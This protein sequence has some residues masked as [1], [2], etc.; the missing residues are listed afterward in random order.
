MTL[1]DFVVEF[2]PGAGPFYDDTDPG[3]L[4]L[5][6][7]P[8][9]W[10][11]T[12]DHSS[13]DITGDIDLRIDLTLEDWHQGDVALLAKYDTATANRSFIFWIQGS[14]GGGK[15]SL[16]WTTDGTTATGHTLTSTVVPSPVDGRLAVRVTLDV[17]N[18]ASGHTATFYTAPTIAGS[19]TTLGTAV[20]DTGTTSFF[21]SAAA[22]SIGAFNNGTPSGAFRPLRGTV[23]AAEVRN[24][25]GGTAVAD[26]DFAGHAAAS[27]SIVD[28]AGRT[29]SIH[30]DAN[31]TEG[32]D[33]PWVDL[34]ARTLEASWGYGRD[35][36]LDT[37]SAGTATIALKN[38]DRALDP[39][40]TA[41]T[42]YGSLNPRTPFRIRTAD[43]DDLFYGFVQGGFEQDYRPPATAVC[44]VGLVDLLSVL[45][46]ELL[47][48]DAYSAEVLPDHP[49]AW[50]RLD[51]IVGNEMTDSSGHSTHGLFGEVELED[52]LTDG[53][54]NSAR[55]EHVGDWRGEV[56]TGALPA[57]APVTLEAWVKFPRELTER[58]TILAVQRDYALGSALWWE[59]A[60]SSAGSPNGEL[61]LRF[62]GLSGGLRVKGSS[63]VDDDLPHHVAVVIAGTT[64]ADI[65]FYVDGVAEA[66]TLFDGTTGGPWEGHKI[67]TVGNSVDSG[68]GDFGLGGLIDEVAV[69]AAA[70][71]A[72]RLAAHY[73]AGVDRHA[74]ERS[75]ARV[76]RVLD[77]VGIPAAMRDI[78]EGDT[79]VGP[80]DYDGQSA[81]E[82]LDRIAESEQGA[83][84]V[85]HAN[86]GVL[87]FRG[88][89]H[90]LTD[91]RSTT[92]QADF[93]D[94]DDPAA[95]HVEPNIQ[96]RPNGVDSII[97]IVEAQWVG[98]T[99][100]A[101]DD[102]SVAR[103]GPQ[104]RTITTEAPTASAAEGAGQWLI[105]RYAE[106]K[107][108]VAALTLAP[109]ADDRLRPAALDLRISDRV[110]LR[111]HPQSVGSAVTNQLYVEGVRHTVADGRSWRVD[112]NLSHAE[113][114]DA[115]WI[116]GTS[117][118]DQTTKW[119]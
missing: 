54:E 56:T 44:R 101:R 95:L 43:D 3:A 24:G 5:P 109:D 91:T 71:N 4:V 110:T 76:E 55:F 33:F 66:A 61:V 82:Y 72:T 27:T 59:V 108:R 2:R 38:D 106:P 65:T 28:D 99:A 8:L 34:T 86:G 6:G 114:A 13:L 96:V 18:G 29:W 42:W 64:T 20:T 52:P 103:Y 75:G 23:H 60:P 92:S 73:S 80:A 45:E 47:P 97:N 48:A 32:R 87:R 22:V 10:A 51:S 25:I 50:W 116:W 115:A 62:F 17:N 105:R 40:N 12:P 1:P 30:G 70:L 81:G 16:L 14:S 53:G 7:D 39:E 84:Y 118:W 78:D 36:E 11:T 57:R 112:L 74:G 88:R 98:G 90:R 9:A 69:Y 21:S 111:R 46:G 49:A 31:V 94:E 67:W 79:N 68:Q 15:L 117:A 104:S 100:V 102:I 19:W 113:A 107:T 35:N 89:Y 26:I 83:F 58:H 41:G 85:D 37:F 77:L 63:T 119:G 93:T